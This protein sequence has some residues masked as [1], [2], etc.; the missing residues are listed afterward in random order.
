M[1][2]LITILIIVVCVLLGAVVLIQNPKG[3]GLSSSFGGMSQ[4]LLGARRS[5]DVVEKLTWGF[6]GALLFLCLSTTFF[7][8]KRAIQK[9]E[10]LPKS[11]I[12]QMQMNQPFT[13]SA[14]PAAPQQSTQE[15]AQQPAEAPAN[16]GN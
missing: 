7:I 3:G 1:Y 6:A 9:K 12:E 16:P 5:T 11:E 10:S 15:P 14:M 2:I 13:P 4:Q 8:D